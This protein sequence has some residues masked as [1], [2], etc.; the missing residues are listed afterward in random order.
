VQRIAAPPQIAFDQRTELSRSRETPA[1]AKMPSITPRTALVTNQLRA[2][3]SEHLVVF[4]VDECRWSTL[5]ISVI[6]GDG[7]VTGKTTNPPKPTL[8]NPKTTQRPAIMLQPGPAAAPLLQSVLVHR[9]AHH[10]LRSHR[11]KGEH[12]HDFL[13]SLLPL[14]PVRR[15]QRTM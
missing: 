9:M 4:M 11:H 2:L 5:H 6:Y 13:L 7:G 14:L 8:P 10:T 3:S 1:A 15:V 12:R